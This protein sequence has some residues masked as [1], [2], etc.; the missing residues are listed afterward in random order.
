[1]SGLHLTREQVGVY[2]TQRK[3]GLTQVTAAA[4]AGF[5]RRTATRVEGDPLRGVGG[6]PARRLYRTRDDPFDAVWET[7]LVPLLRREP[8]LKALTLLGDLQERHPQGFEDRLLRT[9]QRRLRAQL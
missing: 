6:P 8:S 1:M 4:Q 2:M 7:E 3:K 5:S 9:L